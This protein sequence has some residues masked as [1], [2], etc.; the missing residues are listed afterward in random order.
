[1]QEQEMQVSRPVKSAIIKTIHRLE[2]AA[3]QPAT[4]LN[5]EGQRVS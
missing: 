4:A 5:N 3:G 1:M 2:Y